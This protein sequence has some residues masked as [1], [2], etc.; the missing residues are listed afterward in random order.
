MSKNKKFSITLTLL[1]VL[2]AIATSLLC[3]VPKRENILHAD[4]VTDIYEFSGS[5]N[6]TF[7]VM[8]NHTTPTGYYYTVPLVV[9]LKF[10][11]YSIGNTQV[12]FYV[13]ADSVEFSSDNASN[14]T[15]TFKQLDLRFQH[16]LSLVTANDYKDTNMDNVGLGKFYTLTYG[17]PGSVTAWGVPF[18]QTTT[19]LFTAKIVALELGTRETSNHFPSQTSPLNT[20]FLYIRYYSTYSKT[21]AEYIEFEF[22]CPLDYE[23]N[24]RLYYLIS[25]D[26]FTDNES[27]Q[28]GYDQGYQEGLGVGNTEGYQNGYNAGNT[29]GYNNGYSAGVEASNQYTFLSLM[30]S[31]L[32]APLKTFTSLLNFNL[33]GVNMLSFITGLLT[34]AIIIFVIKL[35]LGGK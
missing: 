34:L 24:T 11:F 15:V 20:K 30:G 2:I 21:N 29:I 4:T 25:P 26:N 6:L 16:D 22:Y 13:N 23:Y 12:A 7:T 32:D 8:R 5:N 14:D 18:Y 10:E 1:L 27:F 31:V 19:S 17:D 28:S 9:N 3:L 35:F 33:L